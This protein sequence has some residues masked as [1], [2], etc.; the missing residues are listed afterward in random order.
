MLD[1]TFNTSSVISGS[2]RAECVAIRKHTICGYKH[3]AIK[4]FYISSKSEPRERSMDVFGP[5]EAFMTLKLSRW[6]N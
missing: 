5:C 3:V 2:D 4:A 6:N 1:N